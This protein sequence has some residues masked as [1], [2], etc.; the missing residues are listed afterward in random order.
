MT[1]L[2]S[3]DQIRKWFA[4]LAHFFHYLQIGTSY[5][6][7]QFPSLPPKYSLDLILEI[8]PEVKGTISRLYT[9]IF[10]MEDLS[11]AKI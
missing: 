2:M 11:L 9:A 3:F 8:K 4:L 5:E 7:T 6:I 10:D 1:F